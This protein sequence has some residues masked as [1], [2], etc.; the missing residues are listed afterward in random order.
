MQFPGTRLLS[1]GASDAEVTQLEA[2]HDAASPEAQE[3]R[4]RHLE[5]I[6]EG[7]I[8]EWLEEL[9]KAGHFGKPEVPAEAEATDEAPAD[10]VPAQEPE[11]TTAEPEPE[12]EVAEET[13]AEEEPKPKAKRKPKATEPEEP[14][15]AAE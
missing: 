7:D 3:S 4:I 6:A 12:P 11:G 10:E 13:K 2:E 1:A 9:R 8:V 15:E 5:K 14:V